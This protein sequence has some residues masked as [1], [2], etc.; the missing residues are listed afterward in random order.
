[1]I[2]EPEFEDFAAG[3]AS[4]TGVSSATLG[5]L[6]EIQT[7]TAVRNAHGMPTMG[8]FCRL[9]TNCVGEMI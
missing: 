6:F 5:L 9:G 8:K 7:L 3:A 4:A 2:S 1:M